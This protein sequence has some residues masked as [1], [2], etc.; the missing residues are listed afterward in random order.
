MKPV[1]KKTSLAVIVVAGI[2]AASAMAAEEA[3]L[4]VGEVNVYSYRQPFL[5]QPLFDTFTEQS[6][7]PRPV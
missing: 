1:V 2:A 6:F 7:A 4:N 5:V 3:A